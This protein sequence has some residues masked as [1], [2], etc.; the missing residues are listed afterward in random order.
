MANRRQSWP[1]GGQAASPPALTQTPDGLLSSGRSL[2]GPLRIGTVPPV[3]P[4]GAPDGAF[5]QSD[6][7]MDR[8]DPRGTADYIGVG[9][10]RWERESR[11]ISNGRRRGRR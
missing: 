4:K 6:L 2:A 10:K 8:I 9:P 1:Y 11:L 3:G 5:S 7:G